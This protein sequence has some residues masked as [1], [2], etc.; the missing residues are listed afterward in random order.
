MALEL[1][2]RIQDKSSIPP[3]DIPA[4]IRAGS[5][6]AGLVVLPAGKNNDDEYAGFEMAFSCF[7]VTREAGE[8]Y[9]PV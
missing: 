4:N 2:K 8:H 3:S 9:Y 6:Y 5:L 7:R 1:A